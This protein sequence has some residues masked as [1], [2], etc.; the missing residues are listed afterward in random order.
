EQRL[1]GR[2]V[3]L[4]FEIVGNGVPDFEQHGTSRQDLAAAAARSLIAIGVGETLSILNRISTGRVGSSDNGMNTNT[5]SSSPP[6]TEDWS[7]YASALRSSGES[8][9]HH[10]WSLPARLR[11]PFTSR[12]PTR[13]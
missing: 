4:A 3:R 12:E 9:S 7:G 13:I 6:L 11:L 1:D 2:P 8:P 10:A 5:F